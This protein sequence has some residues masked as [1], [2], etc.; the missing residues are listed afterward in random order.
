MICTTDD[1]CVIVH[2][3]L[4]LLLFL[5]ERDSTVNTDIIFCYSP[6]RSQL[7]RILSNLTHHHSI[8]C[9]EN[10]ILGPVMRNRYRI[11]CCL[12]PPVW[13]HFWRWSEA[14]HVLSS[15]RVTLGTGQRG[16][17]WRKGMAFWEHLYRNCVS[18]CCSSKTDRWD[19]LSFFSHIRAAHSLLISGIQISGASS[20]TLMIG[21]HYSSILSSSSSCRRYLRMI[22]HKSARRKNC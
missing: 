4:C 20:L 6:L 3:W 2:F 7:C 21:L 14:L 22:A 16:S 13:S 9:Q 17:Q 11:C 1:W 12:W 15:S 8:S 5:T 18:I 10:R 19:V